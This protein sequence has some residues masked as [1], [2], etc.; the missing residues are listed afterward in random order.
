M[1]DLEQRIIEYINERD[2]KN[3]KIP[4]YYIDVS[5]GKTTVIEQPLINLNQLYLEFYEK[6]HDDG[7]GLK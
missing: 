2:L 3:I 6:Y 4:G 1:Y 7:N 5:E